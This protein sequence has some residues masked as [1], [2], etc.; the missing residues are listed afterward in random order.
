MKQRCFQ[1][2]SSID[3]TN[4]LAFFDVCV[5]QRLI[6]IETQIFDETTITID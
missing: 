6:N 5:S 4:S 3:E 2:E 1:I